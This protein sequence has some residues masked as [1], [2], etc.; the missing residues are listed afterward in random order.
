MTEEIFIDFCEGRNLKESTRRT[1]RYS[2][3]KY[4]KFNGMTL[5]ELI[6]EAEAEEVEGIRWKNRKIRK[7]LLKYRSAIYKKHLENTASHHFT[8]ILTFYRFFEI[9]LQALPSLSNTTA[10][11]PLPVGFEDM[12]TKEILQDAIDISEDFYKAFILF[13]C[14]TGCAKKEVMSVT[15]AD[16]L[17]ATSDYHDADNLKDAIYQMKGKHVI[18]TFKLKRNKTN[19]FYTTYATPEAM[20]AVNVML[21]K[22][23]HNKKLTD[24]IFNRND[25]TITMNLIELND[26]LEL[27]KVGTYR[28][29]KSHMFRKFH[30]SVLYNEGLSIAEIDAL[31]GRA[32]DKTHGA[33]FYENPEILKKKFIEHIDALTIFDENKVGNTMQLKQDLNDFLAEVESI[34]K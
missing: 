31:Q 8:R 25:R 20:K 9:E 7:R 4:A 12:L 6:D 5:Q 26:R 23:G 21:K 10:N 24:P 33:Y 13:A 22:E 27:G 14:S 11:K 18:G 30:S 1:Y 29:L 17:K 28:R 3:K 32:K 34:E 19:K 2:L 15:V 16:Y